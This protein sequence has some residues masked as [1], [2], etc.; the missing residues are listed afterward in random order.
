M[1]T[2]T[3][4]LK[5]A[6]AKGQEGFT[7]SYQLPNSTPTKLQTSEGST[8]FQK[9]ASL[10]NT[11]RRLAEKLGWSVEYVE[12]AK[13][14]AKKSVKSKTARKPARKSASTAPAADSTS[15]S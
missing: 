12:P 4:T 14:A 15:S 10:K 11:A 1:S 8:L 2:L 3:V 9:S 6:K 5:P 7:G 13:K